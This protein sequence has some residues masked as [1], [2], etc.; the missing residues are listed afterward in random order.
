V[1]AGRRFKA[2]VTDINTFAMLCGLWR[3]SLHRGARLAFDEG[4]PSMQHK[5]P[6]YYPQREARA[7]ARRSDRHAATCEPHYNMRD[8]AQMLTAQHYRKS[9]TEAMSFAGPDACCR[10]S[11]ACSLAAS[12]GTAAA[13]WLLKSDGPCCCF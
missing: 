2:R 4:H 10:A 13:C 11:Q 3:R 7:N 12:A 6:C 8:L 1:L 5:P 9:N